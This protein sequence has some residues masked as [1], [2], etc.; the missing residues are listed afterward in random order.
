MNINDFIVQVALPE[1]RAFAEEICEEMAESAKARGTGIA[2]RSPEYVSGKM[3]EGKAVIAFHKDG[4]WAGFCYIETWS[5]GQFV[6]NSGLIVSPQFRKAGLANAI[7]KEIFGL[8]RALYPKAKI[9]G[10]T[11]GLAVMKINSDLGYEPVTY[12]ELTQDEDFWKGCQSCVNFEILKSKD[13]KICMCTAMLY[14]P[15]E[16]KHEAA[17]NFAEE[18]QK[19]PTLYERF[20]RIKQRLVVK[21]KSGLKS[22]LVLFTLIFNK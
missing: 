20:M 15:A 2:K 3:E 6:A 12:S 17:K 10:L 14:D 8:S 5:H 19:N 21:P 1:H 22:I 13:R 16:K 7:K 4:S 11:T 9:F 18:L